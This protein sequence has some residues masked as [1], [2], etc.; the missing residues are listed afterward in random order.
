MKVRTLIALLALIVAL[1]AV[2]T[3]AFS[4]AAFT[5]KTTNTGTV[6][7]AVDWTPPTVTLTNP[8]STLRGTATVTATAADAETGIATVAIQYLAPG[9]STWTTICTASTA[10]YSC[11]WDTTPRPDGSY[12]LRAI[13]TDKADYT[14]T[15]AVATTTIA[16]AITVS[17]SDPGEAVRGSV[18]LTVTLGNAGSTSYAVRIEYAVAD[19]G[20]WKTLCSA[21]SCTWNTT[22]FANDFYDL[23]AVA[24]ANGTTTT[25][26]IIEGVV[27]DNLAPTVTMTDPGSPLSGVRTFTATAT[28]AHS[29]VEEVTLQYAANGSSTWTT[30]CTVAEEPFSCRYDTTKIADGTYSVRAIATDNAGN[31][32]TSATIANRVINNV[33]ASV[34][35]ED[36]AAVISGSVPLTANA[37]SSAG[38]ASVRIQ[39]APA[40]T[41]VCTV[42]TSPF[43]CTWNSAAVAD[44]LYDFR[45]VMVDKAA[46]ETISATVTARRVD[47]TPLRGLDI[48]SA[49]GG[50]TPGRIEAGDTMTF[51]YNDRVNLGSIVSGWNGSA[52]AVT[53]RAR[54]GNLLGLGSNGDTVDVLR[55]GAVV[56]LGSVNLRQNYV[57][58]NNTASFA[59]TMTASS[60][61]INGVPVTVVT[62]AL[63][64][65]ASSSNRV[66]TVS[67]TASMVWTPSSLVTDLSGARA[68]NA[69]IT[70]SGALD[71][72]F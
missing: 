45:A 57:R 68:S 18:P 23:R 64:P 5:S 35:L 24:T 31:A 14:T 28:D 32:R 22:G 60:V 13:A 21:A 17:L 2:D 47:N 70:E 42:N 10:P 62:V 61:I 46:R 12:S 30:L 58:S 39:V 11:A 63:G 7:A 3:P 34:S 25:S 1:L 44:G 53:L 50:S 59:A 19:S 20:S 16:N 4:T 55:N 38:V 36:P 66:R 41:T 48:Q 9:T 69:P 51:I 52:L 27:V 56:N 26:A 72:D 71:R 29:G 40:W 67:T 8:G 49:N 33:V 43:T 54:D 65:A 37:A 15:S 6:S